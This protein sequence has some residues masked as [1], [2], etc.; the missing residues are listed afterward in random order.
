M[1]CC[2]GAPAGPQKTVPLF[3][4]QMNVKRSFGMAVEFHILAVA[5][6]VEM[7]ILA[8]A[9]AVVPGGNLSSGAMATIAESVYQIV[10]RLAQ[11]KLATWL[12]LRCVVD[13]RR[14]QMIA[15]DAKPEHIVAGFLFC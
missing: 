5:M 13:G 4:G 10:Y 15:I 8:V 1:L 9:M 2:C 11:T 6:A 3:S 14:S 12:C 7:H